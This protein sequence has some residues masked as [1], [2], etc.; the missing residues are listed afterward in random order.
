MPPKYIVDEAPTKGC[1]DIEL[2]QEVQKLL[3]QYEPG[4]KPVWQ[5]VPE[6]EFGKCKRLYQLLP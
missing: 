1:E 2:P 3:R 5:V 6:R 4:M